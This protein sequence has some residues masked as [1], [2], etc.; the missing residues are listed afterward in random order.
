MKHTSITIA[1]LLLFACTQD[2][3]PAAISISSYDWPNYANDPGASKYADLEQINA[4]TVAQLEIAWVWESVDNAAVAQRPQFVPSGFKA[5]PIKIGDTLY[6]STPL[7]HVVALDAASGEQKWVFNTF[8]W[9]HGRPANNGFNHR[10]VA[11]WEKQGADGVEQRIIL[12][13][14]NAFL[15]LRDAET[16]EPDH[17]FGEGGKVDVTL[18]LGR[19]IDS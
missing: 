12:G 9:E 19:P 3:P 13:T 8:T 15:W 1:L 11:Y 16:G 17:D 2:S 18:G 6:V 5:T 14:D 7:G 4:D 10:D